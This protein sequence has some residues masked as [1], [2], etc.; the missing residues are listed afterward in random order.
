MHY[1][2]YLASLH[3]LIKF[4]PWRCNDDDLK[5]L[6]DITET[7]IWEFEE[8]KAEHS[9]LISANINHTDLLRNQLITSMLNKGNLSEKKTK[10]ECLDS[11]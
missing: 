10:E 5:T 8:L 4:T 6:L 7:L 3:N 9:K 2:E 11:I 1:K